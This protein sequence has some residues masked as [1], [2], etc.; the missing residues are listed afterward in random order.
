MIFHWDMA[1]Y[2][3]S[4]WRPSAILELFYY[5][6]RPS[7]PTKSLLLAA[8]A[9]QIS[10]FAYLAW[11]AYSGPQNGGFGRLWTPKCD[12]SSSRPPKGTSLRKSASF[13]LSTVKIRWGVW[14]V[15]ELT[16]SVKDTQTHTHTQV[17]LY[18][19]HA[20]HSIAQT[21]MRLQWLLAE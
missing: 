2:R 16:E 13:K 11:N 17:N 21:M 8:A 5:H 6:T 3:F 7:P 1:I 12:Y 14:P 18:S 15:G 4:K 19:V 9:C 10:F 20:L